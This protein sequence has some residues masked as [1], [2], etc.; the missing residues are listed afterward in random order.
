MHTDFNKDETVFI[1]QNAVAQ[2]GIQ[3]TKPNIRYLINN[4]GRQR[5][6]R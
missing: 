3:T 5:I 4:I 1:Y 2:Y 6:I